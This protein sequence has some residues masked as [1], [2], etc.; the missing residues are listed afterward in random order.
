MH[1]DAT[2]KYLNLQILDAVEDGRSAEEQRLHK[3]VTRHHT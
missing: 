1:R 2:I 3:E